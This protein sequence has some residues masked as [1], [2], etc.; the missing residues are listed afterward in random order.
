MAKIFS[1]SAHVLLHAINQDT[2]EAT[3]VLP[4][5]TADDVIIDDDANT[6]A[7]VLPMVHDASGKV[8]GSIDCKDD[9]TSVEV[10]NETLIKRLTTNEEEKFDDI[11]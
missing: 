1:D 5:N 10:N 3:T 4:T 9:G 11:K 2:N 8:V 6:L 7:E